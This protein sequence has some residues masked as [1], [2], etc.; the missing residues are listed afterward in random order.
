MSA[1]EKLNMHKVHIER[2]SPS[3]RERL[4]LIALQVQSGEVDTMIVRK[5]FKG[6]GLH[7]VG[8]NYVKP[9]RN[10]DVT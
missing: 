7:I 8:A 9:K 1:A 2:L 4:L 6:A 10:N 5:N 3:D